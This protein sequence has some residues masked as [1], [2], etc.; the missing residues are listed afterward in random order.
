MVS[1]AAW[2]EAAGVLSSCEA[3]ATKSR[4][5]ASRR[6]ASVTSR[7][8]S[9]A[10]PSSPTGMAVALVHLLGEPVSTSTPTAVPPAAASRAA[11]WNAVGSNPDWVRGLVPRRRSAA[12]FDSRTRPVGPNNT[13]PSSIDDRTFPMVVRSST[14]DRT[15][16]CRSSLDPLSSAAARRDR[17]AERRSR[18]ATATAAATT[19]PAPTPRTHSMF[20]SVEGAILHPAFAPTFLWRQSGGRSPRIHLRA[21]GWSPHPPT[22]EVDEGQPQTCTVVDGGTARHPSQCRSPVRPSRIRARGKDDQEKD[23]HHGG[24]TLGSGGA[25]SRLFQWG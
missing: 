3:L 24:R 1:P 4:R 19:S 11:S 6:L 16:S 5:T 14:R 25:G 20:A 2:I 15:R 9:S 17:S 8:T 23:I 12:G 10:D 18:I 7:S 22:L 21:H 13:T